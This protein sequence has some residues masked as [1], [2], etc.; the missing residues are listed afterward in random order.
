[1]EKQVRL[2]LTAATRKALVPS[3]LGLAQ[4][5][6]AICMR[7]VR[8]LHVP[9]PSTIATRRASILP[10]HAEVGQVN[11]STITAKTGRSK[12]GTSKRSTR[13]ISSPDNRS[14]RERCMLFSKSG[15]PVWKVWWV[16]VKTRHP[17]LFTEDPQHT[18]QIPHTC[19]PRSRSA[20]LFA[21]FSRY[22]DGS[23][24]GMCTSCGWV[25]IGSGRSGS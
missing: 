10:C 22:Y 23:K 11:I 7:R 15:I 9:K 18:Q 1:M 16:R 21:N 3:A 8:R 19:S 14:Y 20:G 25:V 4:A 12:E 2:R 13:C 24:I 5:R 6:T 17:A